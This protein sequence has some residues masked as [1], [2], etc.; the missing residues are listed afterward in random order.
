M[1]ENNEEHKVDLDADATQHLA[2]Q[3]QNQ[4]DNTTSLEKR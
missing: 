3:F 2:E 4:N 1:E